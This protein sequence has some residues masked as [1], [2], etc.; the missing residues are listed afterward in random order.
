MTPLKY[1]MSFTTAALLHH[2]SLKVAVLYALHKNW[3]E[4]RSIVI[5]ENS[6]QSRTANT[7]KRFTSEITSRLKTLSDHEISFLTEANYVEQGYMLWLALCRRY[8][9]IADFAVDVIYRNFSS[10]KSTVDYED[11]NAYFNNKAEWHSEVDGVAPATK[12]KLRQT[13]FQMMREAGL[14]DKNN[15]I[16]PVIPTP[17]FRDILAAVDGREPM[18][19][20]IAEIARGA[21]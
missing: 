12:R 20:P 10:F 2:E 16:I 4:V 11:Y 14:V 13:I 15:A 9:F 18:Y 8:T 7:L 21:Q 19:F 17:A 6:I 5:A 3:D 1:S